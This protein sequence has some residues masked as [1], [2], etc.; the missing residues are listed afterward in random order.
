MVRR[1]QPLWWRNASCTATDARNTYML[2]ACSH[3][4]M[5]C[6]KAPTLAPKLAPRA[7]ATCMHDVQW[8]ARA[9]GPQVHAGMSPLQSA[10]HFLVK[11]SRYSTSFAL[12][13]KSGTRWCT[14]RQILQSSHHLAQACSTVVCPPVQRQQ[15]Q[16]RHCRDAMARRWLVR[17]A[18]TRH[19]SALA[20]KR[21]TMPRAGAAK[22]KRHARPHLLGLYVHDAHLAR[23][24]LAARLLREEAHRRALVQQPQLAVRVG[25]VAGVAVDAA[26]EQRPVEVADERAD[27]ARLRGVRGVQLGTGVRSVVSRCRLLPVAAA[28]NAT[29]VGER[30]GEVRNSVHAKQEAGEQGRRAPSTACRP[31]CRR[32]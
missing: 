19:A 20:H 31:T 30:R 18:G 27:V 12:P 3:S 2:A 23:A 7:G 11:L 14:C 6:S 10:T 29:R 21:S 9:P 15:E 1:V 8:D 25:S 32:P 22:R 13:T 16:K 26:V 28:A 4:F 5:P 17:T 24:A